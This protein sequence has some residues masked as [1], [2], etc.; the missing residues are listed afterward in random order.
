MIVP[1]MPTPSVKAATAHTA[2][3]GSPYSSSGITGSAA[4]DSTNRSTA[5][6]TTDSTSN[7][8]TRVDDQP[9]C[10]AQVSASS[11]GTTVPISDANPAQSRER[12]DPRGFM[13]GNPK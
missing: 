6:I 3:T 4:R 13:C 8:S 10:V 9:Y 7:D 1:K 11:N 12:L 5:S 2:I